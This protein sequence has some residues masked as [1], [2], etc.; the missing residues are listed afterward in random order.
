MLCPIAYHAQKRPGSLALVT[1][2]QSLTYQDCDRLIDQIP[3][4]ELFAKIRKNE[5]YCPINPKLPP[6]V[7]AQQRE[8][9][10]SI[11]GFATCLFTS[12]STGHPKIACHTLENHFYS[13]M[14]SNMHIPLS[15]G[16]K[17][18]L[19]LPLYHISGIALLFRAF[20]AGITVVLP[21]ASLQPTHVS[22][23]P[24]QLQKLSL[25]ER[26]LFKVILLGGAPI[27]QELIRDNVYPTYGMTEMTSQIMTK[28]KV[29]PFREMDIRDKR[30]FVRGKTLF[31]GYFSEDG[32]IKPFDKEGWFYT[33]DLTDGTSIWREDRLIISGGENI[34]PE[35]IENALLSIKGIT[36][37]RVDSVSHPEWGKRPVARITTDRPLPLE[38]IYAHLKLMLPKYKIPDHI[39]E[40]K[41]FKTSGISIL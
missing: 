22:L 20:M 8:I 40:D 5:P 9:L 39:S 2:D 18:L 24:T 12:G 27:P 4:L 10:S 41:S 19:T 34:Q 1:K 16:D 21:G 15:L 38:E 26:S 30:I 32:L 13:A 29:L 25:Q 7:Q 31:A 6:L 17:W 33:G 36:K 28:G 11:R 35:E 37:A 23:V 14:G 3:L